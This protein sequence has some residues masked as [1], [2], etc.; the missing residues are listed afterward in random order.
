[1]TLTYHGLIGE[2]MFIAELQYFRTCKQE[3]SWVQPREEKP[4]K[5]EKQ[6]IRKLLENKS[7]YVKILN[8]YILTRIL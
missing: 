5:N 6:D 8:T 3:V 1:M 7:I 4:Y 2:L